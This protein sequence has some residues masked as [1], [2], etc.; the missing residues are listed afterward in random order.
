MTNNIPTITLCSPKLEEQY[1]LYVDE[2]LK[3]RVLNSGIVQVAGAEETE[4]RDL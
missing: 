3:V 1:R 2:H 4:W